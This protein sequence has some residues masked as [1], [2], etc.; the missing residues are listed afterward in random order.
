MPCLITWNKCEDSGKSPVLS[1]CTMY[2]I[3]INS[4]N[5]NN[6]AFLFHRYYNKRIWTL[7]L[8]VES[9]L[10][11]L[12]KLNKSKTEVQTNTYPPAVGVIGEN[13]NFSN[14]SILPVIRS[15]PEK[16]H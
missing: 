12:K 9:Y 14:T 11:F 7:F 2:K 16:S 4:L 3:H 6:E 8:I 13:L 10:K 15:F 5:L 1:A